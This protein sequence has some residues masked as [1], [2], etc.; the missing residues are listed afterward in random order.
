MNA[1][2]FALSA[3]AAAAMTVAASNALALGLGRLSVQSALGETLKAEIDVTSLTPEEQAT[4]KVRVAPAES[5]RSAGVDYN[6]VLPG[7]QATLQRRPDGR[8]VLRL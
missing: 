5:Y 3:V 1:G 4:L 6:A 7:T 2:R 8:S